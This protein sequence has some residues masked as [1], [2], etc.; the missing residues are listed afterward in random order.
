MNTAVT[1]AL[2]ML[3]HRLQLHNKYTHYVLGNITHNQKRII[4]ISYYLLFVQCKILI[5]LNN[6]VLVI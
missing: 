2:Y 6:N 4:L 3:Q 1:K 5:S